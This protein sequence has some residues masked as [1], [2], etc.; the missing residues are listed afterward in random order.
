MFC[1]STSCTK[2]S[3]I[4]FDNQRKIDAYL[5][6]RRKVP[7]ELSTPVKRKWEEIGDFEVLSLSTPKKIQLVK[8]GEWSGE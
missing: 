7:K 8:L 4:D 3:N 5:I 2:C 6:D 1:R